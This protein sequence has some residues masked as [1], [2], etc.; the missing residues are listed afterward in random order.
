MDGRL[1]DPEVGAAEGLL[2]GGGAFPTRIEEGEWLALTEA[3]APGGGWDEETMYL[4]TPDVQPT[5]VRPLDRALGGGLSQAVTILGGAPGAG[6]TAMALQAAANVAAS[7]RPVLY[8]TSEL[9]YKDAWHRVASMRSLTQG[10]LQAVGFGQFPAMAS[11]ARRNI[12]VR[13]RDTGESEREATRMVMHTD[14][15]AQA[16]ADCVESVRD[17][18]AV[19]DN[20]TGMGQVVALTARWRDIHPV[21]VV[22]YVQA[23]ADHAKKEYEAVTEATGALR[24]MARDLHVPVLALTS[25]NRTMNAGDR[26]SMSWLRG[27]GQLEFDAHAIV[28]L[29]GEKGMDAPD[30]CRVVSLSTVKNRTGACLE[31]PDAPLALLHGRFS[32]F[33]SYETE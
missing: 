31:G 4:S 24:L 29:N 14:P 17:R 21:V 19:V 7:G 6:K 33:E 32:A 5:G 28:I 22:D 25:L 26:P 3:G 27:S 16:L 1:H 9:T 18:L 8:F 12:R 30:D 2:T 13:R 20:A 11:L 15:V 10:H 23:Y